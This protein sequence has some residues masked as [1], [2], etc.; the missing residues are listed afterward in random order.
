M[1]LFLALL[2][3]CQF[4][5]AHGQT[6]PLRH[7]EFWIYPAQTILCG[8]LLLWFRRCYEFQRLKNRRYLAHR[9][10]RLWHLDR[11]PIFP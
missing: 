6:F 1:V 7:A 10:G 8:A 2:G 5:T 9:A 11:A 4:L 3:L